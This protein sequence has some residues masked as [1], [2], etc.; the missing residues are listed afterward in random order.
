MKMGFK[1]N[2]EVEMRLETEFVNRE[3]PA[4]AVALMRI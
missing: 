2:F 3:K 1:P 4:F